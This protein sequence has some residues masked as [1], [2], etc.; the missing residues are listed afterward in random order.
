M[1]AGSISPH[2]SW[3]EVEHSETAER[4]GI[5]NSVPD[6]LVWV[7]TKTSLLMEQVRGILNQPIKVNSWYRCPDLQLL[8]AFYNPSSQHPH[9]E[10]VDFVCTEF[11]TPADI[12]KNLIACGVDFDQLIL[13]HTWVHI[14]RNS[15]PNAIQRKQVLS[16]LKNKK[17]AIGLTDVDGNAL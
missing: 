11:G 1:R 14:S 16:L 6:S 15:V 3:Y 7:V 9:G 10:A 12:C 5:D 13:E 2:F 8:P 4:S 17:Y